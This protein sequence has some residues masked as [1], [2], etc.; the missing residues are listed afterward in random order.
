MQP[1]ESH[2]KEARSPR[3]A[4]GNPD[5]AGRRAATRSG[6]RFVPLATYGL[7]IVN[8]LIYLWMYRQGHGDVN[9]VAAQFGAKENALI[10]A[11]QWQRFLTPIFLHGGEIHLLTNCLS[12]YWLGSQIEN[13]YG[14]RKYVLLYLVAG[15]TGNVL[16][17]LLSTSAS[18]GA[19]GAIFGLVGAGLVFPLRFKEYVPERARKQIL[20]QLGIVAVINLSIGFT[21]PRIDNFAHLGGLAGGAFMALF[22]IPDAIEDI[23][24]KTYEIVMSMLLAVALAIT[25]TAGFVQYRWAV[26]NPISNDDSWYVVHPKTPDP[27]WEMRIPGD[28]QQAENAWISPDG[29]RIQILELDKDDPLVGKYAQ[30]VQAA[31]TQPTQIQ[32]DGKPAI[33][34]VL[35]VPEK[36]TVLDFYLVE[37]YNR[38][39]LMRL[40]ATARNY[41]ASASAFTKAV[42]SLRIVH[43]PPPQAESPA[44][45]DG[46]TAPPAGSGSSPAPG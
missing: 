21:I 8:A 25:L 22:L 33:H 10:R 40:D 39:I 42:Q 2:P 16:S 46:G 4:N 13:L 19:S 37:C 43:A 7:L 5:R 45:P 11:G 32:I 3:P 24:R 27:W 12:L 17:Y 1:T 35:Q 34:V 38:A 41:A 20:R 36:R 14:W 28:W 6:R 18:L 9:S 31:H 44:P 23:P 29:S 15:F 26:A 30:A